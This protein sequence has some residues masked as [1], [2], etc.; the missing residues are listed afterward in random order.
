MKHSSEDIRG[1]PRLSRLEGSPPD[2][3]SWWG[4]SLNSRVNKP[5]RWTKPHRPEKTVLILRFRT[6]KHTETPGQFGS[7]WQNVTDRIPN[8]LSLPHSGKVGRLRL[9]CNKW[10]GLDEA[11]PGCR[12]CLFRGSILVPPS[13]YKGT[14]YSVMTPPSWPH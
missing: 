13:S 10:P 2:R 12:H 11:L 7:P 4:L 14:N 1:L 6:Q 3:D 5:A 8:R 9:R